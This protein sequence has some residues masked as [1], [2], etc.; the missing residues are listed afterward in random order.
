MA[1]DRYL[2]G[3]LTIIAILLLLNLFKPVDRPL[4]TIES[5]AQAQATDNRT[6]VIPTPIQ[7]QANNLRISAVGGNQVSNLKD[8]VPLGDGRSFVVSNPGG[9]L[10]YQV[11]PIDPT[12][13]Y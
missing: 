7:R 11:E 6:L 10:V 9:F 8:V 13:R 4:A 5:Q 1:R 12:L 3:I 2:H